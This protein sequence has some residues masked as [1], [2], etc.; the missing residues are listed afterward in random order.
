MKIKNFLLLFLVLALSAIV[1]SYVGKFYSSIFYKVTG[2]GGFFVP[3]FWYDFVDGFPLVHTFSLTLLFTAFGDRHKYW[4]IGVLLIP[5]L[6]FEISFDLAHIY[7]P[8]A[9]GL[10]GWVFGFGISKLLAKK[11]IG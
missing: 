7:F 2:L 10:A 5:A 11:N 6:W 4:W 9:L 1:A 8:V 3:P